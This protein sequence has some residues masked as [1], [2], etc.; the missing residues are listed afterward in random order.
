MRRAGA[1]PGD[2]K[3]VRSEA[4]SGVVLP[5]MEEDDPGW[6]SF[7]IARYLDDEWVELPVHEDIGAAVAPGW[8]SFMIARYLDDEWMELP[9]HEDIGAA[10][11]KLYK[12]SRDAG[13]DDVIAVLA[14]LSY[15]LK[16]MWKAGNFQEAFEGP[17]DVANRAAEFLMLRLGRKVWSYGRSNDHIQDMLMDR[18]EEYE[19]RRRQMREA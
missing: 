19:A 18:I 16:D 7:M 11:A 13:D 4:V 9:V 14:K 8:L 1:D 5:P 10:V 12:A 15:G 6:L 2:C 3:A 17:I